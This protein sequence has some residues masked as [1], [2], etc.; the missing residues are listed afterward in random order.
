MEIVHFY[1]DSENTTFM[2]QKEPSPLSTLLEKGLEHG[3][4][5]PSLPRL[6]FLLQLENEP[7]VPKGR[8]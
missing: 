1:R 5:G 2:S 8:Q 3:G 6:N 4:Q 7:T